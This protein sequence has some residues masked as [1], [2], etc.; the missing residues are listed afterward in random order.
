MKLKSVRSISAWGCRLAR[1]WGGAAALALPLA[2]PLAGAA[3]TIGTVVARGSFRV[4]GA[5]VKGNA[6]LFEGAWI[7][8]FRSS[9][10]LDLAAGP[11][12]LL[13]SD[14]KGRIFGDRLILERGSGEMHNAAGF[15]VEARGLTVRTDIGGSAARIS[16]PGATRVRVAAL[17][18]GLRVLNSQDGPGVRT[19]SSR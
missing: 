3:P 14:S 7:E 6:T 10:S 8:T 17:D 11:H 5:I 18:G 4:D 13:G 19:S 16:L 15:R 1:E 9:S 2:L 12:L